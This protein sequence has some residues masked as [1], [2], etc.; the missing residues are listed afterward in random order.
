[1]LEKE[2][3][4]VY[5]RVRPFTTAERT[6]GESQVPAKF[7]HIS[8]IFIKKNYITVITHVFAF[9]LIIDMGSKQHE[10]EK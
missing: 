5:L 1:M 3:L 7:Y 10:D 8:Y 9:L 4:Q 2:H 6:E